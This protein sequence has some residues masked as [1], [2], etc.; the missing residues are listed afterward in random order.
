MASSAKEELTKLDQASRDAFH[1]ERHLLSFSEYLELVRK[2]PLRHTRDATAYLSDMMRHFGVRVERGPLGEVTRYGVFDQAFL[3]EDAEQEALIGQEQVQSEVVRALHNFTHIGRT[4]RLLLLHGPNGSAKSTFIGCI[5]RGLESYS[6][7]EEGALYRVSWVFPKKGTSRGGIGFYGKADPAGTGSFAHLAD[8]DLEARITVEIRDHPLFFLPLAERERL[9]SAWRPKGAPLPRYISHGTLCQKSKKIFDALLLEAE[10]SLE[11]VL[12]HVRVE[13]YFISRRYRVGAVTLGPELSVDARERQVTADQNLGA[14]P[15]S[16][17]SLSLFEASG[18]L[19]DA[20]GG[21]LE[22]SDLLKRPLDAFKYLQTMIE[23][24][25]VALSNQ[26]LLV[27]STWLASANELQLEAFRG[28]PEFESFRGRFE[29]IPVPYLLNF[30]EEQRVYESHVARRLNVHVAPHALEIVARFAV[31]SRLKRPTPNRYPDPMQGHLSRLTAWEKMCL[32]AG[33]SEEAPHDSSGPGVAQSL[34][35]IVVE[36][37]REYRTTTDYEGSFGASPRE[38]TTLLFDAAQD[39]RFGYLSPFGVLDSLDRLCARPEDY[40]FL[41]IEPEGPGYHDTKRSRHELKTW[42]LDRLEDEFRQVSGIIDDR[43]HEDLLVRYFEQVSYEA[44]GEK[45]RNPL[46]QAPEDPD[47]RLMAEVERLLKLKEPKREYRG[48][49]MSRIAGFGLD[50][51]GEPLRQSPV[52]RDLL[53]ALRA[54]VFE[55]KRTELGKICRALREETLPTEGP[56][57]QLA[58]AAKQKL[59]D[60]FGYSEASIR[61]A[62]I[63]LA[64]ERFA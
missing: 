25:E 39:P 56:Y 52:F 22:L 50:H 20:S 54:T 10:G 26:T 3:G 21:V 24:G 7:T 38:M 46:T 18:E 55:E 51:P 34:R 5:M 16:L 44:K 2:E 61:D 49:L 47:E 11:Q 63:R 14:L 28:H 29:L 13:R 41:R 31:L 48:R 17:R 60:H 15:L 23:T 53:A 12:R 62:A 33:A 32:Y 45:V 35:P 40:S 43:S 37:W 4:N 9:L 57:A 64:V 42:L 30:H 19:V 58:A 59:L 1:A 8:E 36:L 6:T 27:N